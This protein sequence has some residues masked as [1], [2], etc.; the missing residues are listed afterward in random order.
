MFAS[1]DAFARRLA[2]E[3]ANTLARQIA[4]AEIAAP[5]GHESRRADMIARSLSNRGHDVHRDAV[6][7]VLARLPCS[8]P[9]V[10][11][12]APVVV[13]AHLD[14]VFS[15]D[16]LPPVRRDGK[17]VVMPGISDNGRGLSALVELAELLRAPNL[18][19][20]MQHPVELVATVGE[21]G[22]G[23][24]RGA[25][26]YLD[27]REAVGASAPTAVIALD[28]PGDS[29]IVHHGIAS[30]R[31][32]VMF[33]GEGGHPWAEPHAA[34]AVH[35]AGLAV[36]ALACFSDAQAPGVTVT[37]TR[38]G[39]GE[40]LTSV[41]ARAWFDVDL[42]A[43]DASTVPRLHHTVCR[44][45]ERERGD[46]AVTY[47]V[48][49]DRPGGSLDAHHPLVRLAADATRWQGR[50]PQA[51]SASTDANI[52]LSRGIPAIAIGAGGN[53]GGTHTDHE[54]YDD[55]DGSR[56]IARALAVVVGAASGALRS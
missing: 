8:A 19:A 7:N 30:R 45:V 34:N 44:L 4:I 42:R 12:C 52:A 24:L 43:L 32:R 37:V 15:A 11:S 53:G 39:G 18:V 27:Q 55:T 25:R 36:A 20:Q 26:G 14:T 5:T 54:W 31:V 40:S 41:P 9:R 17:R 21:E 23:N 13:M 51:A 28:G 48:L 47:H 49:G 56:G 35:A 2:D 16:V 10:E 1:L 33:S 38:I 22:D 46:I 3:R 6:G 29:L 50:E